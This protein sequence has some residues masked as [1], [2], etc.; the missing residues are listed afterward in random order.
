MSTLQQLIL[1]ELK[2][3]NKSRYEFAQQCGWK[4]SRIYGYLARS[5]RHDRIEQM[6]AELGAR[7]SFDGGKTY[8]VVD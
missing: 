8:V 5:T 3:R 2:R 7:I 6:L 1:D 4:P